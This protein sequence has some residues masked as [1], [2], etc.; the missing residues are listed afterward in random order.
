VSKLL[1]E[2]K[3]GGGAKA[4]LLQHYVITTC[5]PR[6]LRRLNH[7]TLAK[8]FYDSLKNVPISQI[9]E[10]L[11]APQHGESDADK[12]FLN[13]MAGLNPFVLTQLPNL[14]QQ[15]N[16]AAAN[17]PY[18]AYSKA[19]CI[20]FHM[21]LCE[22]LERFEQRLKSLESYIAGETVEPQQSHEDILLHVVLYG[23]ALHRLV[24][25]DAIVSHLKA[26]SPLLA[27]PRRDKTDDVI[28]GEITAPEEGDDNELD[29]VQPSAIH[30]GGAIRPLWKSY[31]DWLRLVVDHFDAVLILG[32]YVAS[33]NFPYS[34]L[35]LKILTTPPVSDAMLPWK[36]LL[37]SEHFPDIPARNGPNSAPLPRMTVTD[38][39]D[40]LENWSRLDKQQ[41]EDA[42]DVYDILQ[43]VGDGSLLISNLRREPLSLGIGFDGSQHCEMNLASLVYLSRTL[44]SGPIYDKYRHVL[45]QLRVSHHFHAT[46]FHLISS[47]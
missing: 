22:L 15:A 13:T 47:T 14:L 18:N 8:P 41:H 40:K 16:A 31:L 42:T 28:M 43:I 44:T 33:K 11:T 5:F 10:L 6:M 3:S 46:S 29:S 17:D 19:T 32:G 38:L 25:S 35:S 21:L 20:E 39:I 27:D 30:D 7:R 45:D 2:I 23:E 26:I 4:Y 37:R 24:R 12:V 9:P 36:D 1:N 34:G